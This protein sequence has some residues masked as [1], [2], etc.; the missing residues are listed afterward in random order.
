[1]LNNRFFTNR[2]ILINS[3]RASFTTNY[4]AVCTYSIVTLA[5]SLATL[6]YFTQLIEKERLH[7]KHNDDFER[8]NENMDKANDA[9]DD[10]NIADV[11]YFKNTQSSILKVES[12]KKSIDK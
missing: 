10:G 2:H 3:G 11:V 12:R 1:M 5:S 6:C 7:A 9:L 4:H 8:E